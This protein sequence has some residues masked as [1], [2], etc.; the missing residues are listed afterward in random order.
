MF[1][2]PVVC[3]KHIGIYPFRIGLRAFL[4][5]KSDLECFSAMSG[6]VGDESQFVHLAVSVQIVQ[7]RRY[8]LC[9]FHDNS[10]FNFEAGVQLMQV[11]NN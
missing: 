9:S 6:K 8:F 2:F 3:D 10:G 11:D 5:R 1:P 4:R 7:L